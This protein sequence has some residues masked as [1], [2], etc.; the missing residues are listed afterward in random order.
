MLMTAEEM[1]K[2]DFR[3]SAI[4]DITC[5]IGGSVPSTLRSTTFDSS[6]YDYN[7]ITGEEEEP[8]SNLRN[9]TVMAI[10]NLPCGLPREASADFGHHIMKSIIPLLLGDDRED[11]LGRA[12]ITKGG[13][14]TDRYG[15]LAEWV[16]QE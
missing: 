16:N 13:E 10:D 15:Y 9:V 6:F 7:P 3:I 5:D 2:P 4:A 14:L 12:T 8:F 1:R 11:V